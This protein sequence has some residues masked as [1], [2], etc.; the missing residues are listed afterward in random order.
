MTAMLSKDEKEY[1]LRVA[2]AALEAATEDRKL[3]PLDP[4]ELPERLQAPGASFVTLTKQGALRGCIGAL[5]AEVPL[6][7]DVRQH[8]VDAARHDHRFH[9]VTPDETKS[10][11]IEVSVLSEP[12]PISTTDPDAILKVLRPGVD[13]VVVLSGSRRAT[14]LPQVWEKV[15]SPEEFLTMLCQKAG[16]PGE[17]WKQGEVEILIYQVES[18]HEDTSA[19]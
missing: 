18:F 4:S 9:R 14:F 7:E 10:I 12:Q 13:G 16:M 15:P 17:A 6:V 2:R 11:A 19:E 5:N 3:S 1:L 8:A